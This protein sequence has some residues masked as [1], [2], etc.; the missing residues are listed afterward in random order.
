MEKALSRV[1][2]YQPCFRRWLDMEKVFSQCN[3]FA[4]LQTPSAACLSRVDC[5][6]RITTEHCDQLTPALFSQP[7]SGWLV[8]LNSHRETPA[9]QPAR[10]EKQNSEWWG[11]LFSVCLLHWQSWDQAFF[12]FKKQNGL[13]SLC[14]SN[15]SALSSIISYVIFF[16]IP[17]NKKDLRVIKCK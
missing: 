3:C 2:F 6:S 5:K 13:P 14:K 15:A 9:S 4:F 10:K 17:R 16:L 11:Q 8:L 12:L 7:L 1:S